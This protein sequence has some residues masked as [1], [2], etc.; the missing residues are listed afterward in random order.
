MT[1]YFQK[2]DKNQLFDHDFSL[3]YE[4][5]KDDKN[6]IEIDFTGHVRDIP[7]LMVQKRVYL[8]GTLFCKDVYHF[9]LSVT[10]GYFELAPFDGY[11]PGR[12]DSLLFI[13]YRVELMSNDGREF[14]FDGYKISKNF[15]SMFYE[16]TEIY[17]TLTEKKCVRK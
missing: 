16:V 3:A 10:K 11:E 2:S 6:N 14:L 8:K 5:G 17:F 9:P 13:I 15:T 1:G 7:T 4:V 12:S